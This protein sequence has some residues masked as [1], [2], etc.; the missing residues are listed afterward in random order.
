MH[1][2]GISST[3]LT[4]TAQIIAMSTLNNDHMIYLIQANHKQICILDIGSDIQQHLT[5]AGLSKHIFRTK[6]IFHVLF[7]LNF[8]DASVIF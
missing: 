8:S 3:M 5:V 6:L 4:Y 2:N 1:R 7:G